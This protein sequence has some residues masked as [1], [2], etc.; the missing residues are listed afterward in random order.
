MKLTDKAVA[1]IK[2]IE[3]RAGRLTPEQV[4]EAAEPEG[5]ALHACFDWDD[6]EAA[7]KWRMEQAREIIRSV[8]IEVVI[9]ERTLRTVGYVHDPTKDQ[10][11]AGYVATLKMRKPDAPAVMRAELAA[12]SGRLER[13]V[14]IAYAKANA[15]PDGFA[16]KVIGIKAQ[17]DRLVAGL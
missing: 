8:R 12:V 17:V 14:G 11:V 15:L 3:S 1:E 4:I 9:E 5:S 16:G 10:N 13:A 6:T 2:A 7:R